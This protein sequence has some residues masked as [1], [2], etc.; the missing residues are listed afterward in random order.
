MLFWLPSPFVTLV[1]NFGFYDINEMMRMEP[2]LTA[3]LLYLL[4]KVYWSSSGGPDELHAYDFNLSTVHGFPA[5]SYT[6]V[7]RQ[8]VD[9]SPVVPVMS[10]YIDVNWLFAVICKK[11][12][13]VDWSCR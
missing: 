1:T 9:E 13:N 12:S 6:P 8:K 2:V 5:K 10:P 11:I 3:L 4:T 7:K